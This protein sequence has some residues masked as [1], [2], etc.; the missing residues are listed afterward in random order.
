MG[1]SAEVVPRLGH[2]TSDSAFA[3]PATWEGEAGWFG[4][5]AELKLS[6]KVSP[7]M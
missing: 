7:S 3:E 4:G 5:N 2:L 1:Q 6:S